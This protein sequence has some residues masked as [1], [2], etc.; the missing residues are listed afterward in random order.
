MAASSDGSEDGSWAW[1]S[2]T[3]LNAAVETQT[4]LD[5]VYEQ[6]SGPFCGDGIV[7]GAEE[8]DPGVGTTDVCCA[9]SCALASGCVCP[10]T[11]PCCN[12]DGTGLKSA[13][14]VCRTARDPT[15]DFEEVCSGASS[16][17]PLDAVANAGVSCSSSPA[18]GMCYRGGC[19][20]P[21]GC[22]WSDFNYFFESRRDECYELC[23]N[24]DLE[25]NPFSGCRCQWSG[26]YA[27]DGTPCGDSM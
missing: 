27:P 9:S 25:A 3:A 20:A 26:T 11:D 2:K 1:S 21:L 6:R 14:T 7:E 17:C 8:C 18:G 24:V 15:C 19:H 13:G 10:T 23:V 5:D 16:S 4:C 12:S 22:A